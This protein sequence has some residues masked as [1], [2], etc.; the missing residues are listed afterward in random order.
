MDREGDVVQFPELEYG[1]KT[2]AQSRSR[3][4]EALVIAQ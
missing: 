1:I 4:G 2:E 3:L